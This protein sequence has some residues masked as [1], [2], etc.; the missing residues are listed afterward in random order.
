MAVQGLNSLR[1]PGVTSERARTTGF[2][3]LGNVKFNSRA[4]TSAMSPDVVRMQ[5]NLQKMQDAKVWA[6]REQVLKAFDKSRDNLDDAA[7]RAA[8][9]FGN[10]R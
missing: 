3:S 2:E 1:Q 4:E 10:V 6:A 7:A 8:R 5:E 9:R